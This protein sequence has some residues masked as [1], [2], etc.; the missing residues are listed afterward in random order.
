VSP[1]LPTNALCELAEGIDRHLKVLVTDL[2]GGGLDEETVHRLR[3]HGRRLSRLLQLA[4]SVVEVPARPRR[5]L[6]SLVRSLA[7]LRDVQIT[8][9][10]VL[11]GWPL[12]DAREFQ[13]RLALKTQRLERRA[14]RLLAEYDAIALCELCDQ[15]TTLLRADA[16]IVDRAETAVA[17]LLGKT[18]KRYRAVQ[19]R[20]QEVEVSDGQSV[21]RLRI[22]LRLYRYDTEVL[23]PLLSPTAERGIKLL[24]HAQDVLGEAQDAEVT[25]QV[26]IDLARGARPEVGRVW[27]HLVEVQLKVAQER[28][29][30]LL[31]GNSDELCD[32]VFGR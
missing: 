28:V 12:A 17:I 23:T 22:A 19:R 24:A 5:R 10:R 20:R 29:H 9:Q 32:W 18:A 2:S 15:A 25:R 8:A 27:R 14:R 16:A 31:D 3:V 6:R 26:T 30:A 7:D 1:P 13:D 21:H 11:Q 4:A